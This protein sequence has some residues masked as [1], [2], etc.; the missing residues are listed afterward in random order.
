MFRSTAA[1]AGVLALTSVLALG[2]CASHDEPA[3]ANTQADAGF[4]VQVTPPG[5]APLTL[6]KRP[7]WIVSL[8]PS[9]TETLFAVGA[10]PQVVAVDSASDY[11]AQAPHSTLSG[12]NPDPEAIAAKNPDLVIVSADTTKLSAALAKTGTKT[13]VLPDAKTLDGAYAQFALIG[14]AT[15]HQAE[16]E[17]LAKR[18]KADI[19]KLVADTPKPAKPLTYY[20]EL[21]PTFYSATS[22]TFLG[23][24]Y[25]Q[26]G[27]HNIADGSDPN[28]SGGY[29]QLSA[30][31]VL[32]ANPDL[33]FLADSKCCG[34]NAKTVTAR[35]GWSTMTAVQKSHIFALD[36]DVASRWS[37]RIADL[38]RSI[39]DA[40]VQASK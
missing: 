24:L 38:A 9:A 29:P 25:S 1:L 15:G 8:S 22:A 34:Q 5:G 36:D 33:I 20:H 26:F 21:D 23:Q 4:P 16:G 31:T 2:G 11:P 30:E 37:P 32:K 39:A 6:D 13:L 18:T 3:P 27:L 7:V 10:G 35:P 19:D 17:D 28:A 14:K 12:L 40:V